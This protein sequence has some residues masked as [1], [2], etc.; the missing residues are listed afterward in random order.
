MQHTPAGQIAQKGPTEVAKN[1]DTK[2]MT[3][4]CAP[5]N[6]TLALSAASCDGPKN[7]PTHDGQPGK[8]GVQRFYQ[9]A[10]VYTSE[11][12]AFEKPCKTSSKLLSTLHAVQ[13]DTLLHT[14]KARHA[15]KEACAAT[16][17]SGIACK[18][19]CCCCGTLMQ[20]ACW[21]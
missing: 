16:Q 7:W 17:G 3:I 5:T 13:N 20:Y 15:C 8:K 11:P 19:H 4:T 18:P 21:P 12:H 10:F 6:P 2:A 1:A 14:T 9:L